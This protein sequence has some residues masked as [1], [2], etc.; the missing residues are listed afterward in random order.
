MGAIIK[1]QSV[2]FGL[3]TQEEVW[4]PVEF[5][6]GTGVVFIHTFTSFH[7]SQTPQACELVSKYETS[8]VGGDD[9]M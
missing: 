7:Y 6:Q 5:P 2:L 1:D 9:R 3:A 8:P 4:T